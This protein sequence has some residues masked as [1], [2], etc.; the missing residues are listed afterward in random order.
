VSFELEKSGAGWDAPESA[1]W[2]TE[3]VEAASHACFGRAAAFHGEGGS[4]PFMGMLGQLFPKAQFCVTG[5]LGPGSNAHG[6]DEFLEIGFTKKL[7]AAV[8]VI[9]AAHA[10][11]A[12][13]EDAGVAGPTSH[14]EGGKCCN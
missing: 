11:Q 12:S 14:L 13:G 2:L 8:S 4:I 10:Q 1:P 6:P 5:V 7:I 9:L 3:A